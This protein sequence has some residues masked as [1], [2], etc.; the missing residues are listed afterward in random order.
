MYTWSS[1]EIEYMDGGTGFLRQLG[2]MHLKIG[3]CT[4]LNPGQYAT[5]SNQQ[6]VMETLGKGP[7]AEACLDSIQK[8]GG[9][10]TVVAAE[11]SVQGE[12]TEVQHEGE[13]A[14]QFEKSGN[15]HGEYDVIVEVTK[16]GALNEAQY[17]LSL[18]G[19]ENFSRIRTFPSDGEV[20]TETG[21]KLT[22]TEAVEPGDSFAEGDTYN[23]KTT[24]PSMSNQ[25][26]LD[27]IDVLKNNNFTYEFIHVVGPT[28][29]ALW[30]VC[31]TE[32]DELEAVAVPTFFVCETRNKDAE[33]SMDEYVQALIEE[34]GEFA[35]ERIC[36]VAGRLQLADL[37]GRLP[38]R[39]A[40][41]TC[42]AIIAQ[43]DIQESAGK[44]RSFNLAPPAQRITPEGFTNDH[45]RMLHGEGFTVCRT[46]NQYPGIYIEEA[47]L[48]S[49]PG[50]DYRYVKDRRLADTAARVAYQAGM[51]YLKS[52]ITEDDIDNLKANMEE[53]L[54]QLIQNGNMQG[55]TLQLESSGNEELV[56][57]LAVQEIATMRRFKTKIRLERG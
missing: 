23:F 57:D 42:A 6:Q 38:E 55:Y 10:I 36:V 32:A 24:P 21:V 17:R 4:G 52:E 33:E 41:A 25:D 12:A 30:S 11:A 26:F 15:P 14:A 29:Q 3:N 44:V 28:S 31:A 19:G 48:M 47:N 7:L 1:A 18:D 22:F 53:P 16:S 56:F 39:N 27:A 50:S 8:Q 5:I 49:L 37:R 51:F 9:I 35:H 40:G 54:E 43:S 20:D 13:G 34:R 46:Y 2:G 45:A